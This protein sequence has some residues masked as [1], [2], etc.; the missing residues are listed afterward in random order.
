MGKRTDVYE[1]MKSSDCFILPSRWE[2]FP[3]TLIEAI[4]L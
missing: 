3:I 2:G 4:F 1:L